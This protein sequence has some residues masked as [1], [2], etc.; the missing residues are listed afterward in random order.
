MFSKELESLIQATLQDG[1]LTEQEKAVLIRRA[2]NEGV[3]LDEL[4]I[5]IQS[6]L[7]KRH[8]EEAEKE[9]EEDRASKI[10]DVRRCPNCGA[11]V[12]PGSASCDNCGYAFNNIKASSSVEKLQKRL[13]D[14]NMSQIDRV[15][16]EENKGG[17]ILD[18][19]TST[20]NKAITRGNVTRAKAKMDIISMFPV[21]IARQDLL[22]MLTMTKMMANSTGPKNGVNLQDEENLSYAYWLLFSNCINK[23]KISFS[24]DSAFTPYIQF[25]DEQINRTKGFAGFFRTMSPISRFLIIAVILLVVF[26]IFF[27]KFLLNKL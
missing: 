21:P 6:L 23:A 19:Y 8:Q 15:E 10:G 1:L 14:Y 13:D 27:F 2:Q 20:L 16:R 22:E 5:Y 9:A 7:Q 25:Y 4:D 17:N 12:M 3:D 11:Q 18:V 26:Y 24:N